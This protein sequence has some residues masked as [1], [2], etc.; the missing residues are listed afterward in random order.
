M[1]PAKNLHSLFSGTASLCENIELPAK[2][3]TTLEEAR[4]K[5]R[6][7]LRSNFSRVMERLGDQ[8]LEKVRPKFFTQGSW[9][10]K[11]LIMPLRPP[12][13]QA[14]LDDGIYLPLSYAED[15]GTP[16]AASNH[17]T[18]AVEIILTDLARRENWTVD[19]SNDNC[20][21]VI[22]QNGGVPNKHI[23]VPAYSMPDSQYRLLV[24]NRARMAKADGVEFAEAD[25]DWSLYPENAVLMAHKEKGWIDSDPRPVKDWVDHQTR[26]KTEQ[27]RRLIRYLKA[28]RD[29]QQW[30]NGDPKSILLMVAVN[31]AMDEPV[32]GRDDLAMLKVAEKLPLIFA[33]EILN[34]AAKSREDLARRLDKDGIRQELISMSRRL[35]MTLERALSVQSSEQEAH[36]LLRSEWGMRMP[37]YSGPS[38]AT[39]TDAVRR[40]PAVR[41]EPVPLVGVRKSG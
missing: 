6:H 1:N 32:R 17:Y 28:W 38:S 3:R 31:L 9:S 5:V 2:D 10:Y 37:S 39:V 21:R 4:S 40:T 12:Q 20:T 35:H 33:G 14:D 27:F 36:E 15:C 23:D 26:L 13:Q 8:E 18:K 30:S 34:P 41:V 29:N 24:E 19:T 16:R 7:A 25:D 11:T 22:L